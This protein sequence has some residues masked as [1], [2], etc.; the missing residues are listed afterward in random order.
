MSA[1]EQTSSTSQVRPDVQAISA[2]P[3]PQ[4]LIIGGGINGAATFR[5]LALQGV[6]VTLIERDD[7]MAGASAASSH[8][9]HGGIRYLENGEFRLVRESVQERNRLLKN[10]PHYVKPLQTTIP[11]YSTFSGIAAAPLR[12]L[13]HKQSKTTERGALLI[14]IG[15]ILYD[16][17][18]RDGGDVPRHQFLG[19]R[20][21]L[22][23]LPHLNKGLKYTA[24][25]YDAA[26]V[27]PER[28]GLD[29]IL[30]GRA[31]GGRSANYVEAIGAVDGGVLVRDRATG[32]EFVLSAD[33][34]I[35]TSGPWTD[36]TNEALGTPS[37]FMGGTKGSHIVLDNP[38][39]F[40]ATKGR[41]LFFENDDGRIVL[42][43][44]LK[45]RVLVGTTDME[46]DPRETPVETDEDTEYFFNLVSHVFPDIKIHR[47]QIVFT[48]AG[49]RPL[50]RHDDEAPGFVSRDYRIEK[51]SFGGSPLLSLVG[52]KWT[53]FRALG[54]HMTNEALAILGRTRSTSTATLAVGGGAG[55]P[56]TDAATATWIAANAQQL[57]RGRVAELL[58]RYGTRAT[59]VMD[60]IRQ[61]K[62]DHP[63]EST[64]L[65]T[66]AEVGFL[67]DSEFVLHLDD[68]ILRRTELAFIGAIDAAALEELAHLVGERL[69][70]S[71]E[72]C[73]EEVEA[74]MLLLTTRHGMTFETSAKSDVTR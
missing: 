39:L 22:A 40:A 8:M 51:G 37:K 70:W 44:P 21:S 28:L 56:T 73:R 57:P 50:P 64:A 45:G 35:N 49:I 41:E 10:A 18:S 31:A 61:A 16:S 12:F 20:K 5:E 2:N 52:G 48:Y 74:T 43:Y 38:E 26:M 32:N 68:V 23:A 60:A 55:F 3:N 15:L 46:A 24:T 1:S 62:N 9:I 34:V 42:I 36:L 72:K 14:K 67:V 17:F 54:E 30:D 47:S 4:V 53:T 6:N 11:I 19:R 25:Y 33:L 58:A 71:N 13:T 27:H 69:G 29:V 7:Y 59:V 66:T 63:L 65:L